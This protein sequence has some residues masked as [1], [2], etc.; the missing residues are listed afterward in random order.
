MSVGKINK[1][2]YIFYISKCA[3]STL[4]AMRKFFAKDLRIDY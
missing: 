2:V 4:F 1:K 3:A